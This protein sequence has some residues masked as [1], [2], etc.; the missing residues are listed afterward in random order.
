MSGRG[1]GSRDRAKPKNARAAVEAGASVLRSHVVGARIGARST[2]GPYS[3]LRP[4]T[5]LGTAAKGL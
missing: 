3:Y 4:G 2:V 5:V 1:R